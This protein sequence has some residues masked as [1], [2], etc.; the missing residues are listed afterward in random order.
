MK[1][2]Y[3]DP[4]KLSNALKRK[5]CFTIAVGLILCIIISSA[6]YLANPDIK[7][8]VAVFIAQSL[9]LFL[10]AFFAYKLNQKNNY[11]LSDSYNQFFDK[12]NSNWVIPVLKLLIKGEKGS[13]QVKHL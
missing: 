6:L 13:H 3:I 5:M 12:A 1:T 2:Y 4:E 7:I 11:Q 8:I 9:I 10:C